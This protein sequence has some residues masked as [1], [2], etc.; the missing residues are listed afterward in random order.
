MGSEIDAFGSGRH[1]SSIANSGRI[2][3]LQLFRRGQF[4]M[5]PRTLFGSL[6]EVILEPS[7][8]QVGSKG[9]F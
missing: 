5:P 8:R 2:E 3:V 9:G 6:F 4:F 7:W 1:G